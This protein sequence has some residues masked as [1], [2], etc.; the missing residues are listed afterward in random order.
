MN[1]KE[2]SIFIILLMIDTSFMYL[3]K[4]PNFIS[5]YMSN[6]QKALLVAV[7]LI[8]NVFY[9]KKIIKN[10]F[11]F[12][13][14]MILLRFMFTTSVLL[15]NLRYNQNIK[16]V[17]SNGIYLLVPFSYFLLSLFTKSK[18]GLLEFENIIIVLGTL[19]AFLFNLQY[20]MY[21]SFNYV[22]LNIDINK[23]IISSRFG[24]IRIYESSYLIIF[25]SIF[26][27]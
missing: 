9:T 27:T 13:Y 8:I 15:G 22:F 19:Q 6:Y 21:N 25:S 1:K 20:I 16:D 3:L 5:T 4:F 26:K 10:G 24:E 14:S 18:K 2:K 17:L 11:V 23:S 7:I 12:I